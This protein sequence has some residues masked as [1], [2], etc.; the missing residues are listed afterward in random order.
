MKTYILIIVTVLISIAGYS[1]TND[2]RFYLE[3]GLEK[4]VLQDHRGAIQDFT[5]AIE[6]DPNKG[7]AYFGRGL[8]KIQLGDKN[9]GCLDLSKAGELGYEH[10]YGAIKRLCN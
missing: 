3:S 7:E 9:S 4:Q 6:L 1:Q 8:A 2:V 5:K 10:A